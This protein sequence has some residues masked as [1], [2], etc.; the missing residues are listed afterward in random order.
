M[1]YIIS[2]ECK[3]CALATELQKRD[4]FYEDWIWLYTDDDDFSFYTSV[5]NELATPGIYSSGKEKER[6]RCDLE[7]VMSFAQPHA[8]HRTVKSF[9]TCT[10]LTGMMDRTL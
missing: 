9:F 2:T 3:I 10:A 5:D 7:P 8:V 6:D 1:R 4:A